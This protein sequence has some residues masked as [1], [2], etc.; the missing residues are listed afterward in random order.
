MKHFFALAAVLA[1][2][3]GVACAD[4][5]LAPSAV[6]AG[7]STYDRQSVTVTGTVKNVQT[8]QGPRGTITQ[9]QLCDAQ[10]V[11]VVQFGSATVS[12]GQTQTITG[13]FRASVDR[14]P[15]HAQNVIMVMPAGGWHHPH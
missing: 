4:T 8:K 13:R 1:I 15:M 9:Y 12:E 14:G 7:A 2:S 5:A 6:V 10:C 11:N 3:A